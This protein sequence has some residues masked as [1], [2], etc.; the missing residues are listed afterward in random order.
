MFV[1]D[2]GVVLGCKLYD[3]DLREGDS[4]LKVLYHTI[5]NLQTINVMYEC[6]IVKG[7]KTQ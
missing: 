5:E 7:K 4:M 3:G 6:T 1:L 2:Y